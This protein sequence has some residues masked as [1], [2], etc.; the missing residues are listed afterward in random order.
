MQQSICPT[1]TTFLTYICHLI[2][3]TQLKTVSI[4]GVYSSAS[5]PLQ[6]T[7]ASHL[8]KFL[9]KHILQRNKGAMSAVLIRMDGSGD[10]H[11]SWLKFMPSTLHTRTTGGIKMVVPLSRG[12]LLPLCERQDQT[13]EE[14]R[15]IPETSESLDETTE[16][17]TDISKTSQKQDQTTEEKRH[18]PKTSE[19][20]DETTEDN[21]MVSDRE[22][23]K[24]TAQGQVSH[25]QAS[26][27]EDNRMVSDREDRK[28]TAQGRVYQGQGSTAQDNRKI[29]NREDRKQKAQGQVSHRQA[30][31]A[32][33][34]RKISHREDP[35]E[36]VQ[37]QLCDRQFP[38]TRD[39][40]IDIAQRRK[41]KER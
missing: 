15:H 34:K 14:K 27:T 9:V 2:P 16:D 12:F 40:K 31:T 7:D 30:S 32:E 26:K 3:D 24:Q 28:E 39:R 5:R 23:H 13:T 25:R 35:K 19:S 4:E 22:D 11:M 18:I 36:T 33:D 6:D 1:V 17:N 21:R 37:G 38:T 20:L 8:E 29:A 10:L 41:R